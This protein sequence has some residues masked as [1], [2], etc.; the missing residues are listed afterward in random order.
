MAPTVLWSTSYSR[1]SLDIRKERVSEARHCATCRA[2]SILRTM[3]EKL[4]THCI[5]A[6]PYYELQVLVQ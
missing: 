5:P 1:T 6:L 4:A 3:N 2:E